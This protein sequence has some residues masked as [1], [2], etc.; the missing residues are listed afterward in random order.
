MAQDGFESCVVFGLRL[1]VHEV[2]RR[3]L[4]L[5][6]R[7]YHSVVSSSP[8]PPP[9]PDPAYY[10]AAV[11]RLACGITQRRLNS[12]VAQGLVVPSKV[13]M[14]RKGRKPTFVFTRDEI[15]TFRL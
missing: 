12:W 11:V 3:L 6:E 9:M 7:R 5:G 13:W 1:V 10:K 14:P 8:K 2:L 15:A 4:R